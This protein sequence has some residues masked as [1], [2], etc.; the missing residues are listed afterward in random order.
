MKAGLVKENAMPFRPVSTT[1]IATSVAASTARVM[2]HRFDR[3][4][5]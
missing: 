5:R 3:E 1:S 4:H 2:Q